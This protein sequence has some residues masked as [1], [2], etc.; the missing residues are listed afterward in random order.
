MN[1][2]R[3]EF[4]LATSA[5]PLLRADPAKIRLGLVQ[6]THH[7][8]ANPVSPEHALDAAIVRDM[9]W[10]AIEYGTPRAGSLEA[11]IKPGSWVVIKPNIVFLRPSQSYTTG[12]ITDFRVTRAVLEYVAAKSKAR[13]IT[14]AEGGSYR[15]TKDSAK[16]DAVMQ[17]G[18]HVDARTFDW[19]EQEFPGFGGSLGDLLAEFQQR[20]PQ[21]Q[22]DYADLSYDAMR[23]PSGEFRRIEV[24]RGPGGIGAFGGRP[25]YFVTNTIRNCDFL[26]TVPV[27]KVHLQ[28]GITACLKNYVGTAPREAYSAPGQ[29]WNVNLHRDHSLGGRIDPFIA[30]LASFHPPDYCVVD[31]IR[32]LQAQEHS[33]G[34]ADQMI[35]SNLVI[36]GEDPVAADALVANLLGFQPWDIDF[37]HLA[38]SRGMG[39]MDLGRADVAGDDPERLRRRWEKPKGWYGR[40]NR[41]WRVTANPE[42]PAAS[43]T[44]HTSRVDT[45]DLPKIAGQSGAYA[46]ST[47]IQ[48]EGARKGFLWIGGQGRISAEWNGETV[49]RQDALTRPRVGQYRAAIAL[50]S[51]ENRLVIRVEPQGGQAQLSALVTG[52]RNDGDTV[53]GIRW[54][55]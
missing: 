18:R 16:D 15:S 8:L 38:S 26:I 43:W 48:A 2:N 14:I 6:S 31:G 51:G 27:M 29:F 45:L 7:R 19:G 49:L 40:C 41:E 10:K 5:A 35:R 20:Y 28:C 50:R 22:F 3:R 44:A 23:T 17:N 36:A 33:L 1:W 39:S 9:V 42:A 34:R 13:R 12:D 24:P 4:L 52:P 53:E 46:V 25:D 54:S 21:K 30:D 55:A 32:G 11:K 47:R 37:L